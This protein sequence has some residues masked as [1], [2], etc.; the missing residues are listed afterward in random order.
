[1]SR[2][3]SA[4]RDMCIAVWMKNSAEYDPE[5]V[6][7]KYKTFRH[8]PNHVIGLILQFLDGETIICSDGRK[9]LYNMSPLVT[10]LVKQN[11]SN[12]LSHIKHLTLYSLQIIN[13]ISNI[14]DKFGSI[15]I[16]KPIEDSMTM[17]FIYAHFAPLMNKIVSGPDHIILIN[18]CDFANYTFG[19]ELFC[20]K[21]V[22]IISGQ[23]PDFIENFLK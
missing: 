20:S 3:T 19:V 12:D 11:K 17:E 1:M 2:F 10:K 15:T 16:P 6:V 14:E 7:K 13:K 21:V 18:L 9:T 22:M 4:S 23:S 5:L 8:M